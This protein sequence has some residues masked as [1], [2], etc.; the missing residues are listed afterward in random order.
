[1]K[2]I[3]SYDEFL[4]EGMYGD[5]L[6]S[7]VN[8]IITSKDYTRGDLS[9]YREDLKSSLRNIGVIDKISGTK[10]SQHPRFDELRDEYKNQ[11][12]KKFGSGGKSPNKTFVKLF[13]GAL[14]KFPSM[15]GFQ[16]RGGE[17]V[18]KE[19]VVYFAKELND[20][21]EDDSY[22]R[23][24][25]GFTYED[26]KALQAL[27][28]S[29]EMSKT[30]TPEEMAFLKKISKPKYQ[31][32][33]DKYLSDDMINQMIKWRFVDL[34][35]ERNYNDNSQF[36]KGIDI[37]KDMPD[38][39]KFMKNEIL[40]KQIYSKDWDSLEVKLRMKDSKHS[41]VVSS[42]FSTTYYYDIDL[43]F[44]GKTFKAQDV[45]LSSSYYSGGWN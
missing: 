6:D 37:L 42:S 24:Y 40:T 13:A 25:N 28:P 35:P 18:D 17:G 12:Y 20:N 41:A 8:S 2:H 9:Y 19:S 34:N 21:L 43:K 16:D 33:V 31:A 5:P 23:N 11:I 4:N 38:L 27:I 15:K 1:M 7:L 45:A 39:F 22:P 36:S 32:F 14:Q 3:Q 10:L 44:M 29:W 30:L 26:R